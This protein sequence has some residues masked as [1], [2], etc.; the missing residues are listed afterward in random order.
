M[1][2]Q[3]RA[4]G[5]ALALVV[6]SALVHAQP[7]VRPADDTKLKQVIIFARHA[8]RSPLLPN[9]TM[10]AFSTQ[11]FPLFS[12]SGGNIT[13]NGRQNEII[14]G[15]YYRLRLTKEGLLTGNDPADAA[16]VYARANNA[17]LIIDTAQAF[18]TGMLPGASVNVSFYPP[19]E[20]D[21]LFVPVNAGVARLD[22]RMAV[23][24]VM[25]RLGGNPQSLA[26]AYAPELALTRS[27]LFGYPA[28]LTPAPATPAGKVDVTALPFAVTAGDPTLPVDLGGFEMVIAAIDPF[29][30]EYADGL[31]ASEVGWGQLTA[32]DISQTTRLYNLLLDLE[33][34]TPYL[35]SVQSSNA[36]SHVVR[37]LV[38]AATGNAMTGALGN[39]STKVIVLTASNTTVTG[40][41]GLF[42]LDW[43]LPGYQADTCSPGGAL[44]FE[45][46]QSQSTGEYIVRASYVSQTMD[47]LRNL[48]PLT[49]AA[50]PAIGPVFI[51][52]CSVHNATFDCPLA[53]FVRV[54]RHAID[55]L[56]ADL[57]N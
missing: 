19:T 17:P 34:R 50:P 7:T 11:P 2:M 29:V 38:Q 3:V 40:L 23:A 5:L 8:V 39:P 57:T 36:A 20:S 15:G 1:R 12:S 46:R 22:E 6:S 9:S 49:L 10:D 45:L 16:F 28:S 44:V 30:M 54:A 4:T 33:F 42:H 26:S 14:L 37:S 35:D 18:W 25:G 24:A 55:P 56:S 32:G 21:P 31:P 47:Q 13:I 41:A 43:I 48:T 51:P 53:D 27:I 52:G